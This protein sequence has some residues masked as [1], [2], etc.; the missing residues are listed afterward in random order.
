MATLASLGPQ[1]LFHLIGKSHD[2]FGLEVRLL[3]GLAALAVVIGARLWGLE[4][5]KPLGGGGRNSDGAK[6][7]H[8]FHMERLMAYLFRSLMRLV[9][10]VFAASMVLALLLVGLSAVLLTVLWSLLIGRKPAAF[11]TF[12]RFRDASRQFRGG[13]WPGAAAPARGSSDDIVDVQAHEVLGVLG[14][15]R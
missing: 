3:A 1:G 10:V 6:S 8:V 7:S 12:T 9:L 5:P 2:L 11:A 13:S 15:R 14:D 4:Y